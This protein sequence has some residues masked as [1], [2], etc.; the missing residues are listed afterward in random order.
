M[1]RFMHSLITASLLAILV[2]AA[3][4]AE[5]DPDLAIQGEYTGTISSDGEDLK[6][7][8]QVIALGDGKFT[9]VGYSGGLPGDGWDLEEPKRVENVELKDGDVRFQG[10]GGAALIS[11]GKCR[12]EDGDGNQLGE[13]KRVYA[14]K[15]NAW[16][17]T[18]QRRYRFV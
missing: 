15:Q 16:H 3:I 2:T 11:D 7:G 6:I 18:T 1:P 12:I 17:E 8:V 13:L 9:G 10:D 14:K 5:S 4:A